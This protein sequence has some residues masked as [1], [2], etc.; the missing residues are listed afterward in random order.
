MLKEMT[1]F[2]EIDLSHCLRKEYT[3]YIIDQLI[4]KRK[5]INLV[6]GKGTGKTRLL[7]DIRDCKLTDVKII[8][9]DSKA[10]V[11][12]YNGLLREIQKQL[13][14][15]GKVPEKLDK[16]FEALE[17]QPVHYLVFLDNYDALL[18][19]P[20]MDKGYNVDFFDDLNFIKNKDNISLLCATCKVHSSLTVYIDKKS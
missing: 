17:K 14:F 2:G 5:S 13:G 8:Q 10:H 6:G 4:D 9:V 3:N 12:I 20:G 18:G 15:K 16:L 11:N 7:E 19:N 1:S